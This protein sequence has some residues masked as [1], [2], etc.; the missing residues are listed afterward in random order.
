MLTKSDD[1]IRYYIINVNELD[2]LI[3]SKKRR[4][5]LY[6]RPSRWRIFFAGFLC[7]SDELAFVRLPDRIVEGFVDGKIA[8]VKKGGDTLLINSH[9]AKIEPWTFFNIIKF[10]AESFQFGTFQRFW[11]WV[12]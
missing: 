12:W 6:P 11:R 3:I 1:I 9:T 7:F 10:C 2:N 5:V 8:A 4:R